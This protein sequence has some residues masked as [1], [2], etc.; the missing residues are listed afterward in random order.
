[1]GDH[2]DDAVAHFMRRGLPHRRTAPLKRKRVPCP[3]CRKRVAQ[4]EGEMAHIRAK[5]PEILKTPNE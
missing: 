5:H 4:G 1:M 2:A 3:V